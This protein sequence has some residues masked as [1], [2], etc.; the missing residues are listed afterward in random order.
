MSLFKQHTARHRAQTSSRAVRT[1]TVVAAAGAALVGSIAPAQ[2]YAEIPAASGSSYAA[3]AAG[4][5]NLAS[6]T[7]QAP[8]AAQPAAPT[9][10]PQ[11]GAATSSVSP[12]STAITEIAP[13]AG[14]IV[15]TAMQGVGTGYVWGGT[16]FGAWDCSGFTGWVYAQNGIDIPR[17]SFQQ[18]AAATPTSNPQPGDLVSQN[19]GNHIGIYI[20]GGKMVSALN[21]TQGTFVHSVNAMPVDGYYTYR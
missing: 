14:G 6:Y 11:Q 5:A 7:T 17:T 20:G 1:T 2:A 12:Q 4:M 16:S 18:I 8:V 10:A 9:P 15:G 21:P 13:A 3:P 19:G